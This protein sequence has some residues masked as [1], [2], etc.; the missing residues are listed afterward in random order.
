LQGL[1]HRTSGWITGALVVVAIGMVG[2]PPTGGFFGK[3]NIMLGAL[4]AQ[5]YLAAFAVIISTLLTL[6]YFVKIFAAWFQPVDSGA[7]AVSAISPGLK[8]SLG[9]VSLAMIVLGLMS[10]TVVQFLLYAYSRAAI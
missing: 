6:G 3:W 9:G 4:E 2:L 5:H 10:D 1:G 7:Q 8:L